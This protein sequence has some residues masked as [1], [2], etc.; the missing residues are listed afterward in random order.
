MG[1]SDP[2]N[3]KKK[4]LETGNH[5]LSKMAVDRAQRYSAGAVLLP[6][7]HSAM[8]ADVFGLHDSEAATVI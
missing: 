1:L 4:K 2:S 8:P 6:R 3:R 7:R 5:Y